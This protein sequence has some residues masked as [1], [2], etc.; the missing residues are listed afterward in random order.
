VKGGGASWGPGALERRLSAAEAEAAALAMLVQRLERDK[1]ALMEQLEEAREAQA[2]LCL[3]SQQYIAADS[4]IKSIQASE[5]AE[6]GA[7]P[8]QVPRSGCR[9]CHRCRR[10]CASA[11]R[12]ACLLAAR[13]WL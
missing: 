3:A 12:A 1:E 5:D 10:H 7:G 6:L 11:G 2:E 8:V 13:A 9:R 4:A